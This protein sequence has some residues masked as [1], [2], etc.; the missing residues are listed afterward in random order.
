[1]AQSIYRRFFASRVE[2]W[3]FRDLIQKTENFSH[4]TWL[5]T[6]VWQN[7]LDLWVMQETIAEVRPALLIECGTKSGGS[8]LFFAHIFDLMGQG[9]VVTID[10]ERL[11]AITHPRIMFLL[12]NSLAPTVV[13]T[14]RRLAASARGPVMVTLDSDHRESH[15]AAE[16]A[17]YAPLVTPGSFILVQDGVIDTQPRFAGGRPGPLR[18]IESFLCAHDDFEIDEERAQKFLISHHPKGWLRRKRTTADMEND[19]AQKPDLPSE[20]T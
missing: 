16:L 14:V 4:V 6:P 1:M 8:A 3:F 11:H 13:E 18:A 20:L 10:V 9:S 17:A 5:G 19:A 2:A 12:G 15:V 7:V